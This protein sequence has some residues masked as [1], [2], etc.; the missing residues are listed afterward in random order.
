MRTRIKIC[1][2]TN[3]DDALSAVESGA[4]ALGFVFVAE[5]RRYVDPD[6]AREII[7]HLPPMVTVVGVFVNEKIETVR[8]IGRHCSLDLLQF[9]GMESPE[10]CEWYPQR[11]IKAFRVKDQSS[12]KE[13]RKYKV[14]G[15]LLDSYSEKGFGGTGSPF[16]WSLARKVSPLLPVLLAGG[17]DPE[18]VGQAIE[19]VRPYGVDVSSGVE[20]S[21]GNKDPEKIHGFINAVR[22]ADDRI[23]GM[24]RGI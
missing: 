5:S 4:D 23:Y 20:S 17:L 14:H 19:Q 22:T 18:N 16:D 10:Y 13:I 21:A 1:G 6:I 7:Q 3:L 24:E 2:I 15:Y 12:I 8:E 11:V 9:H